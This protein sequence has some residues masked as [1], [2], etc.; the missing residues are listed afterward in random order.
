MGFSMPNLS[1]RSGTTSSRY[2]SFNLAID[3]LP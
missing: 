2:L 3:I 1:W